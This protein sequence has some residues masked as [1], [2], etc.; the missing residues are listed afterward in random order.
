[1]AMIELIVA[2]VIMGITLLAIPM[3]NSEATKSGENAMLQESVAAGASQIEL[4]LTRSWD[5]AN[6]GRDVILQTDSTAFTTL[7]GLN[8]LNAGRNTKD[9]VGTVNATIIQQENG[10]DDFDDMDDFD[11]IST[12]LSPYDK[13]TAV[14]KTY[15]G[16]YAD[17]LITMSTTVAYINDTAF[18]T[19]KTMTNVNPFDANITAKT[20]NI[21]VI[22]TT[23]TTTAATGVD[24]IDKKKIELKTFACN[25]GIAEPAYRDVTP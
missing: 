1:M 16:E 18:N 9:N 17:T 3:I 14:Y 6:V 25:I 10:I 22:A 8:I 7:G 23:L 5:S 2:L 4:I 13:D 15:E 21:K 11:A 12:T 19:A 24:T 20:S